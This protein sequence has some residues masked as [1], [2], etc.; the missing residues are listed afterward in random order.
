M[1]RSRCR[2][3]GSRTMDVPP[4]ICRRE[5]GVFSKFDTTSQRRM[6]H[7]TYHHHIDRLE[8]PHDV[9]A[10]ADDFLH[11]Y[12]LRCLL[13][14]FDV[15]SAVSSDFGLRRRCR[16]GFECGCT[17]ATRHSSS[18]FVDGRPTVSAAS[19]SRLSVTDSENGSLAT[20]WSPPCTPK[21]RRCSSLTRLGR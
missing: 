15:V 11:H 14:C 12:L 3:G 4:V 21:P 8:R 9:T 6:D 20:C 7:S 2:S 13:V 5:R 16:F 18:S 19:L 1:P 17:A 10:V